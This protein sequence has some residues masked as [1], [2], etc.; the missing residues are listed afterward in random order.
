MGQLYIEEGKP[1]IEKEW[2]HNSFTMGKG[3]GTSILH[4]LYMYSCSFRYVGVVS[5]FY[6]VWEHAGSRLLDHIT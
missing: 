5:F 1:T 2:Q 4:S 3:N 6:M